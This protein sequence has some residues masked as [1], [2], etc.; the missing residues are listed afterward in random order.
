MCVAKG[1]WG[2][3][4][5]NEQGTLAKYNHYLCLGRIAFQVHFSV[6]CYIESGIDSSYGWY[7][8]TNICINTNTLQAWWW[9]W[10]R[11]HEYE[12][13][14][15]LSDEPSRTI[16]NNYKTTNKIHKNNIKTRQNQLEDKFR[17]S[18]TYIHNE[19]TPISSFTAN[20]ACTSSNLQSSDHK[21]FRHPAYQSQHVYVT[22]YC[23]WQC[24]QH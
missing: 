24:S 3:V 16:N 17:F 20:R 21:A 14:F 19:R 18:R 6:V 1:C 8:T 4:L 22:I 15:E 13:R 2:M 9:P 11:S 7:W 5:V 23:V 10:W 12:R